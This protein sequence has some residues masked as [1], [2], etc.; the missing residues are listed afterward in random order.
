MLPNRRT[1][2]RALVVIFLAAL[3]CADLIG[4]LSPAVKAQRLRPPAASPQS[5]PGGLLSRLSLEQRVKSSALIVEAQAL[6]A[7]SFWDGAHANIYTAH[8]ARVYKVFKGELPSA[9]LTVITEGGS[10]G[11]QMQV[12]SD[13]LNL[14]DGQMGVFFL[15]PSRV[16]GPAGQ[17]AESVF[18]AYG[19]VQGFIQYDL[20][21]H[22]AS[23]P[24]GR[25][26]R[27]EDDLYAQ[28]ARLT[29]RAYRE[30]QANVELSAGRGINRPLDVL[31][32]PVIN[33]LSPNPITA[34]TDAVLTI[35]GSNFGATRGAGFV[36]FKN[37]DNGGATFTQPLATDYVSWSDTQI[38]V[39]VPTLPAPA[40]TGV[41]RVTN[42]N[43]ETGTSTQTLTVSYAI[44]NVSFNG[45]KIPFLINDDG[46]GGYTFQFN[47]AFSANA[48]AAAAFLRAMNTWTCA[49]GINWK[50]GADTTVNVNANDNVNVVA[51]DTSAPLPAGVIGR[52]FTFYTSCDGVN[53][54]VN[55]MDVLFD[56]ATNWQ[57][58]PGLPASGQADF[59]TVALHELGHAHQL[60]HV[61]MPGAV[62]HFAVEGGSVARTLSAN[63]TAAGNFITSRSTTPHACSF[64]AMVTKPC[65]SSAVELVDFEALAYEGGVL[66]RWQTGR[67]VDNLGFRLYREQ[68]GRRA[69]VNAQMVAGAAL[70]PGSLLLAGQSYTWWDK[71]ADR[72]AAYWLEDLDLKGGATWH[73]PFYTKA[74]GGKPLATARA[75]L[76]SEVGRSANDSPSSP[77]EAR[78][79]QARLSPAQVAQSRGLAATQAVKVAVKREGWYRLTQAE[80]IAAGLSPA[81]EPRFL[82]LFAEG[83]E[84]RIRVTG[85]ADGR[86]DPQDAVEFYGMGLDS[87]FT[88][89][90]VYWLVA[91]TQPGLR[92]NSVA[93]R[94]SMANAASFTH[95]VE[96][97]DRS[98]YF[99]SLKNGERENFFG[100]VVTGDAVDQPLTLSH[101][102][103]SSSSDAT[104]EVA[105]QGVTGVPHQVKVTLNSIEV[106]S[107]T[108]DG[109][110]SAVAD[111]KVPQSSLREG[112]NTVSLL[113][114]N[115]PGDVSLVDAVRLSYQH[116]FT[117]DNDVLKFTAPAGRPV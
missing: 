95:T 114:V 15:E 76:L 42:N 62:M 96:Q 38:Q 90:R 53:W 64:P 103:P 91:G 94:G 73:G 97:R 66:L 60:S 83:V 100:A 78:A 101:L 25:Y 4:C 43:G 13:A 59:E 9:Q 22:T 18:M 61:I 24:F 99:S 88:D 117:A 54:A 14:S 108:F 20:A 8:P 86:F 35:T 17:S 74:I 79:A 87:P 47:T 106:G 2:R 23:D 7:A 5:S 34:G 28:L 63:D 19:S 45:A 44:T 26:D 92:V 104:L 40:G 27:I 102:A 41:I 55:E 58:G 71:S 98:V 31:A 1:L 110:A 85:E 93:G 113:A 115:G 48:P 65:P 72:S 33:A 37:A 75:A 105:L 50:R 107:L 57:Y 112:R 111:F 69:L 77:V 16:S 21:D 32:T 116:S 80:L 52:A 12:V 70:T 6:S 36:E 68:G 109:Q 3:S 30:V 67:E 51:F 89:A 46:A 49:T 82:Q 11:D 84:Q 56:D 29:G 10:V 81:V 39:R